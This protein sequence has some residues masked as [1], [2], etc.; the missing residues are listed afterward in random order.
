MSRSLQHHELAVLARALEDDFAI[1]DEVHVS[2]AASGLEQARAAIQGPWLALRV[3][4]GWQQGLQLFRQA[5]ATGR[6]MIEII[7]FINRAQRHCRVFHPLP[8]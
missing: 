5:I 2:R 3:Q 1:D 6:H 7:C 4:G 8:R